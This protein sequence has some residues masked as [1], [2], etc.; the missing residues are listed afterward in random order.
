MTLN[1]AISC[2]LTTP[3]SLCAPAKKAPVT[4]FAINYPVYTRHHV[5]RLHLTEFAYAGLTHMCGLLQNMAGPRALT[6]TAGLR[7]MGPR[8]PS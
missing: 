8:F 6:S 2:F 5:A 1:H 3:A 4:P 7:A